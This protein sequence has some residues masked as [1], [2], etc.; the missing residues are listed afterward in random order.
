MLVLLLNVACS[1]RWYITCSVVARMDFG[2]KI[3]KWLVAVNVEIT[4]IPAS[5]EAIH[6]RLD[7]L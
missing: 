5:K 2:L 1:T 7:L 4:T 6:A 3:V